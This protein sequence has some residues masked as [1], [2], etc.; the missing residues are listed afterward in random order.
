M[1]GIVK[2]RPY[3]LD[4]LAP[5]RFIIRDP[6]AITLL[7]TEGDLEGR[8]F[9]LRSWRREG[10]LARL[11][12]RGFRVRTLDDRVRALPEPPPA[13]P[14]GAAVWR[15]LASDERWSM[16]DPRR[17]DWVPLEV[18][19]RD[20]APGVLVRAGCVVRRRRGRRAP[21]FAV[22]GPGMALYPV[23][24]TEALLLG[25]AQAAEYAPVL[26]ARKDGE[27]VILPPHPLPRPQRDFLRG[28]ALDGA[29]GL[30]IASGAWP[31]AQ[32]VY[33]GLGIRLELA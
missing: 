25:Y 20:Q 21:V 13:P 16:F 28:L 33:A 15:P 11:R 3:D 1:P 18:E 19:L 30:V 23:D 6:R 7:K 5:G 12:E 14:I 24:E 4:E 17:L 27:R 22:A 9:T 26:R 32:E 8:M 10:L 29:D 2:I 31:L